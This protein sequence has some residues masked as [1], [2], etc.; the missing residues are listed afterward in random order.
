VDIER[1]LDEMERLLMDSARVPFTNKRVI[2]EDELAG[3]IDG[4]RDNLPR[5]LRDAGRVILERN[6]I[7]EEAQ[8]E[9]QALVDEARAYAAR[10]S[11]EHIIVRQAQ[12]Q[13]AAIIQKAEGEARKLQSE[14]EAYADTV[15]SQL[16][17]NVEKVLEVVRAARSSLRHGR[18]E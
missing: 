9:S 15:F 8:K 18:D 3:L 12:E 16:E 14:V 6:R 11:E 10:L 7:I 13:A 1:I 17:K 5:E 2:E 4:L